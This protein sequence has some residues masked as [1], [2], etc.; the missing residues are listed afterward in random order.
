[1]AKRKSPKQRKEER[2]KEKQRGQ[3]SL[4]IGGIVLVAVL[5]AIIF[6]LTALP[7]EA[8]IPDDLDRYEAFMSGSTVEGYPYLGNPNAPVKVREYSSFACPGCLNFHSN[9]FPGLLP[10]IEAGEIQ[11]IYVP[12]QTGSVPNAEGAARTAICAG[13]QG[14]FW[15][16]MMYSSSGMRLMQ[17]RHSKMVVFVL[18]WA[19]LA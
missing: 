15:K 18:L 6:A 2:K 16:C 17:I 9:V 8:P 5:A 13:E 19:N 3:Q 12:L 14:Q 4:I 11:F 7:S 1:M 10:R